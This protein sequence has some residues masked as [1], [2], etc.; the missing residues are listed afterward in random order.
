MA[1]FVSIWQYHWTIRYLWS[2]DFAPVAGMAKEGI[3]TPIIAV[4]DLLILIGTFAF[5]AVLLRFV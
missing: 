4:T 3:Q 1:L 2:G 5:A